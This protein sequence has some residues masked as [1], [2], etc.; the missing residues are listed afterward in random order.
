VRARGGSATV[1]PAGR[2]GVARDVPWDS[3]PIKGENPQTEL[4]VLRWMAPPLGSCGEVTWALRACTGS[5]GGLPVGVPRPGSQLS[6]QTLALMD[7][8]L[9]LAMR[10][11]V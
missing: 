11:A 8:L 10:R 1:C 4:N 3:P 9:W 5:A 2:P 7:R 6:R